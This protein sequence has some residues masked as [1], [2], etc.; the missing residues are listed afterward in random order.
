MKGFLSFLFIASIGLNAMFLSGCTSTQ[1]GRWCH[2]VG[3]GDP[4]RLAQGQCSGSTQTTYHSN[5][6]APSGDDGK[7]QLARIATLLDI[8]TSGK[9]A[10]DLVSDILYKLDRPTTPVPTALDQPSYDK[11][12]ERL[13]KAEKPVLLDY[14]RFISD[15][16]GKRVIVIEPEN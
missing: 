9:S 5:P 1:F 10:S 7:A 11:L 16:Q 2:K 4:C 6:S 12:S 3:Y 13:L 15:L 14:Q 8:P